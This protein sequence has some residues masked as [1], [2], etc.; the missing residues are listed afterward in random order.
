MVYDDNEHVRICSLPGM[1]Q[2]TITI[3]SAGKA[4]AVTGW[5]TGWAIGP[6]NLIAHLQIVHQNSVGTWVTP[7]QV[8]L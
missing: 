6:A 8:S 2:R 3:G 5:K 7:L 1:W 4:L